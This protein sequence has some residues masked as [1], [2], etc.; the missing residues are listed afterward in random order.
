[1]N[2]ARLAD[3][4]AAVAARKVFAEKVKRSAQCQ[5]AILEGDA[6]DTLHS[7][8][9]VNFA[10]PLTDSGTFDE[11][12]QLGFSRIHNHVGKAMCSYYL[13]NYPSQKVW[14]CDV[15]KWPEP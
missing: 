4:K 11:A 9:C 14:K 6:S 15:K 8:G 2:K 10:P 13:Q 3:H 1:M 12:K 5:T 7:T